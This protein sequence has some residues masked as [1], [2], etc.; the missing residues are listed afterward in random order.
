M[1]EILIDE[2]K[3]ISSKRAAKVTGYAKDYVGQLC[4]E[5]RV[6]AR[7]VGRSWYV[8]ESALQ[9]HRF[10][11]SPHLPSSRANEIEDEPASHP[12]PV[13]A[14]TPFQRTWEAPRY[15]HSSGERLPS[16][17][18]LAATEEKK[19]EDAYVA[20]GES[21]QEVVDLC[22]PWPDTTQRGRIDVT[23]AEQS[24]YGNMYPSQP[25]DIT[26]PKHT[27]PA[28][29]EEESGQREHRDKMINIPIH[30]MAEDAAMEPIIT[31]TSRRGRPH[32]AMPV[33]LVKIIGVLLA[34]AMTTAAVAGS[35]YLD[36]YL[37]SVSRASIITGIS[38]YNK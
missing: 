23:S 3:Y 6:P 15:V 29:A 5:G 28:L 25:M 12:A 18:R 35:G 16:I 8:L 27:R 17:N 9:D 10:G 19:N 2:K 37:I 13:F 31:E 32:K 7:L 34:A 22:Q 14:A 26:P 24:E 38:E 4:R 21:E 20:S 30:S 1:D 33:R 36:Q 11:S